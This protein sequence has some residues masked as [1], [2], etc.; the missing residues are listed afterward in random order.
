MYTITRGSRA[1]PGDLTTRMVTLE[2]MKTL[3]AAPL[4][5]TGCLVVPATTTTARQVATEHADAV[6][7]RVESVAVAA[8]ADQAALFVRTTAAHT[9]SRDVVNVYEVRTAAHLAVRTPDDTRAKLFGLLVAPVTLPVSLVVAEITTPADEVARR[10]AVDH[11]DHYACT[12]VAPRTEVAIELPS[13][14][15]ER[16]V[17]DDRGELTFPIPASEPYEGTISVHLAGDAATPHQIAY[18]RFVPPL[19]AARAALAAC[20]AADR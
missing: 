10:T 16:A 7:G 20:G 4:V 14:A 19:V 12:T 2:P 11:T 18:H 13:G 5:L 8:R 17:T 9:C 6:P 15:S 1:G 3:A